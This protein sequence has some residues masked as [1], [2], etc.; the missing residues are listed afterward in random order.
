MTETSLCSA[1][2][3]KK[4]MYSRDYYNALMLYATPTCFGTFIGLLWS[5]F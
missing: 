5:L 4:E 3:P 2:V 1:I